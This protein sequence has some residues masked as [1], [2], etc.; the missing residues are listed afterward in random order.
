[1][2]HSPAFKTSMWLVLLAGVNKRVRGWLHRFLNRHPKV[3]RV[4]LAIRRAPV[5]EKPGS[6]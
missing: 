3:D 2:S 1:M 6:R 4:Y 5:K